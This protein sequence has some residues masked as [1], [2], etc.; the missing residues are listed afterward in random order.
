MNTVLMRFE[1]HKQEIELY[2]EPVSE[3]RTFQEMKAIKDECLL[4]IEQIL[5]NIDSFL[6]NKAYLKSDKK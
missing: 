1:E 3:E 2:V 4:Y 5:K 6:K